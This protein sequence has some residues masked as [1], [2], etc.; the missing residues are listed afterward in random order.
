[1]NQHSCNVPKGEAELDS[2]PT[3][4]EGT[5]PFLPHSSLDASPMASEMG[6]PTRA[7]RCQHSPAPEGRREEGTA[8]AGAG[9]Y[10]SGGKSHNVAQ[11]GKRVTQISGAEENVA[12]VGRR[13]IFSY[14]RLEM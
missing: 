11:L 8:E 13:N 6:G 10:L 12:Y 1:M 14:V 2:P 7:D 5:A 4:S 9:V 3:R